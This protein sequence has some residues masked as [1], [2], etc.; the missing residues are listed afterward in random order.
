MV[1]LAARVGFG[2]S[3][4]VLEHG[5]RPPV[6]VAG[7]DECAILAAGGLVQHRLQAASPGRRH[8]HPADLPSPALGGDDAAAVDAETDQHHVVTAVP[9]DVA[10][11]VDDQV[12]AVDTL[13][14]CVTTEPEDC[15][16]WTQ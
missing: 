1:S 15:R 5:L 12:L 2:F 13:T 4:G 8:G 9:L 14:S 6:P 16:C 7:K 10:W 3:V 11:I